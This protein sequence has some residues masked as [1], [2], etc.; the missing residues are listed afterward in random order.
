M[1][2]IPF[3]LVKYD[4]EVLHQSIYKLCQK[5]MVERGTTKLMEKCKIL[6]PTE[7]SLE[8]VKEKEYVAGWF[9]DGPGN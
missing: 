4:T 5:K 2:G 9:I 3:K 8:T 1:D 6:K 7:N